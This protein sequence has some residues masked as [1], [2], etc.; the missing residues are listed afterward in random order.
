MI[1]RIARRLVH[2][3]WADASQAAISRDQR[4]RVLTV[5]SCQ[6]NRATRARNNLIEIHA[7]PPQVQTVVADVG[8]FNHSVAKQLAR[9][10]SVPLVALGRA[11]VFAYGLE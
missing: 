4:S 9:E 3:D 2:H 6:R 7:A 10:R 8:G 5:S 11:E 1:G